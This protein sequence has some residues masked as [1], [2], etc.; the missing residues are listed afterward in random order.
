MLRINAHK[1]HDSLMIS[2]IISEPV[3]IGIQQGDQ[4]MK[5]Q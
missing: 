1:N 3:L 2:F 4:F 5:L